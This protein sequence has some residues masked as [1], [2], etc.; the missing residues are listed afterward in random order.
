MKNIIAFILI[1]G[2]IVSCK[3]ENKLPEEDS[4]HGKWEVTLFASLESMGY[5]KK[6]D[7]NPVITFQTDGKYELKLDVNSCTGSYSTSGKNIEITHPGCTK[8]CCDSKFSQKLTGML[9]KV[10]YFTIENHHLNLH[11]DNWGFIGLEKID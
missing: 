9:S 7:Y 6:D 8:I 11:V 3:K 4:L 5:P 10:S 1:I 2:L